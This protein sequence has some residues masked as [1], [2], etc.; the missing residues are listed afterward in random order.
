MNKF[1]IFASPRTGSTSL[2]NL[3]GSLYDNQPN[4]LHTYIGEP[5]GSRNLTRWYKKILPLCSLEVQEIY[6]K[7]L[8]KDL[9]TRSQTIEVLRVCYDNSFGIKHLHPHLSHFRNACLLE[10]AMSRGYKIIF[11]TRDSHVLKDI[12]VQLAQQ[13]GAWTRSDMKHMVY[14]PI[15]IESLKERVDWNLRYRENFGEVISDYDAYNIS[16]EELY[17]KNNQLDEIYKIMDYLEI[18]RGK[19]DMDKFHERIDYN[20]NKQHTPA[21]YSKIPNINEVIQFAK[22]EYDEDISHVTLG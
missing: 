1:L 13:S 10:Y 8:P 16:Y 9:L 7:E 6:A 2:V 20:R 19:L 3:I 5:F 22:D 11:L 4:I 14:D 15:D 17:C 21:L 12:S 18:D